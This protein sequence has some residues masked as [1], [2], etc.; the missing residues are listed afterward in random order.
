MR[1][2]F[3]WYQEKRSVNK[4]VFTSSGSDIDTQA[5]RNLLI[6]TLSYPYLT[7]RIR[8]ESEL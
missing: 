6:V 4:P 7:Q 3:D 5:I 2:Q 8:L 1:K